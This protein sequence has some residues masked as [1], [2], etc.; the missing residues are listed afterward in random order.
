MDNKDI[1]V[2]NDLLEIPAAYVDLDFAMNP[3]T[4]DLVYGGR[5]EVGQVILLED[6]GLRGRIE[7]IQTSQWAKA[8]ADENCRWS[9]IVEITHTGQLVKMITIYAD[10]TK[11]SRT[12]HRDYAWFVKKAK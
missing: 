12:Y 4:D 11:R 2:Y 7:E 6:H 5:L 10:G 3:E 9:K 1:E 8:R